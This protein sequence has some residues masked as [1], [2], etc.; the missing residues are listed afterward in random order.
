MFFDGCCIVWFAAD[1]FIGFGLTRL[2]PD[3]NC[4]GWSNL[5]AVD[6]QPRFFHA[7]D[8]KHDVVGREVRSLTLFPL[9]FQGDFTATAHGCPCHWL[10]NPSPVKRSALDQ[11]RDAE[12]IPSPQA[13]PQDIVDLA[14]TASASF[15][16]AVGTAKIGRDADAVVDNRL[17]VHGLRGLR[18][19][20]ASVA[21]SIISG[22]GTNAVA[23]MIG[24]RAAEFIKAEM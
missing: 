6:L 3:V 1:V 11:I 9:F 4:T 2:C 22:P 18:V 20:D 16:H 23:Y 24:G 5:H 15:G 10:E 21:P 13:S 17:R 8:G 12:V 7:L 14:K 19:A